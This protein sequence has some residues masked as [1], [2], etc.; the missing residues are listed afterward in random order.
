ME[1]AYRTGAMTPGFSLRDMIYAG[2]SS[3]A[4]RHR[5]VSPTEGI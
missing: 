3:I 5:T 1:V 4:F 2:V